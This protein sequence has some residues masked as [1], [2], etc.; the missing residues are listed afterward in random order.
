MTFPDIR[1][2]NDGNG[3][4][5]LH[6][7]S[8]NTHPCDSFVYRVQVDGTWTVDSNSYYGVSKID[9]RA[10]ASESEP[11]YIRLKYNDIVID[12]AVN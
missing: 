6:P 8:D 11:D 5:Y 12:V 2:S 4:C 3:H 10:N 7:N 9:F 1:R